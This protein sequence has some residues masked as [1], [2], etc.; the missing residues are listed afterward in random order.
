MS[1]PTRHI[2][3]D[4]WPRRNAF[5]YFWLLDNW[6]LDSPFFNI[7]SPLDVGPLVVYCKANGQPFSLAAVYLA[8]RVANEYEP[9]RL[10]IQDGHVV[11]FEEVQGSRTVLAGD[12][13]LAFSYTDYDHRSPSS[14]SVLSRPN[15]PPR[16]IPARLTSE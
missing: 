3:L 6:L 1:A 15:A 2:E 12:E 11:A 8:L 16:P 10:R 4:T 13:Q 5:E 14:V 9:F 7:T